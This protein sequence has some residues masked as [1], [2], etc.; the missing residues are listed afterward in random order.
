[1]SQQAKVDLTA[2]ARGQV[3]LA[4][5]PEHPESTKRSASL[6]I[7]KFRKDKEKDK[8]T[9]KDKDKDKDKEKAKES[10]GKK[11]VPVVPPVVHHSEIR[12]SEM[13]M[14]T[15]QRINVMN[16]VKSGQ[17]TVDEAMARVL[18]AEKML[19]DVGAKK[20]RVA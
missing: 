13:R 12:A 19:E 2:D 1:M 9:E 5:V 17:L 16:L 11:G 18:D 7:F 6:S 15:E 10:K 3:S 20:V 14:T 8:D 4:P